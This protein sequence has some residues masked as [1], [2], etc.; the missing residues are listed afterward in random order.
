MNQYFER[1]E[2]LMEN[3]ALPS[4][5]RFMLQDSIELRSNAWVPRKAAKIEGP[6]PIN[7]V[8][9]LHPFYLNY[10]CSIHPLFFKISNPLLICSINPLEYLYI[11]K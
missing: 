4:R 9:K 1:M 3:E 5:I 6:L 11:Y 7:Q 2:S 10:T 8:I